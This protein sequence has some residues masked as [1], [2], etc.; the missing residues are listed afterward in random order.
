MITRN[1]DS[2]RNYQLFRVGKISLESEG[3]IYVVDTTGTYRSSMGA[4]PTPFTAFENN[5][6]DGEEYTGTS[7]NSF[8]WIGGEVDGGNKVYPYQK[9][10][11]VQENYNDYQLFCPFKGTTVEDTSGEFEIMCRPHIFNTAEAKWVE[12][13]ILIN[14]E[15]YQTKKWK[16]KVT[17]EFKNI[18]GKSIQVKELGIFY[19]DNGNWVMVARE[20]FENAIIVQNEGYFKISYEFDCENLFPNEN[21]RRIREYY[22]YDFNIASA[23]TDPGLAEISLYPD[24]ICLI[25]SVMAVGYPRMKITTNSEYFKVLDWTEKDVTEDTLMQQKEYDESYYNELLGYFSSTDIE[26]IAKIQNT[27]EYGRPGAVMTPWV[28]Y[29]KNTF[30]YFDKKIFKENEEP[31]II[32]KYGFMSKQ[33]ITVT[34]NEEKNNIIWII[35]CPHYKGNRKIV[36]VDEDTCDIQVL[37]GESNYCQNAFFIDCTQST[38][39][40]FR[41]PQ[42]GLLI[43]YKIELNLKDEFKNMSLYYDINHDLVSTR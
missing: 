43:A 32:E 30:L 5:T 42:K 21:M 23:W 40:T 8:L 31:F 19:Y 28:G 10:S 33:D 34:N 2:L 25:H 4:T 39:H 13:E 16:N 6:F 29:L 7:K 27:G 14:G 37:V 38:E 1:Y 22:N 17:R 20:V 35:T 36:Q 18:S 3:G 11:P 24:K 12:E 26:T 41:I 9:I 15:I